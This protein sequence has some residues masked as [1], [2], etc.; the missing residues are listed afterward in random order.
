MTATECQRCKGETP[1][2]LCRECRVELDKALTELPWW[3]D[4]LTEA[5]LGQTRMS[6]NAGRRSAGRRDL[7]GDAELA[8]CIELLPSAG[9]L[10]KA[11]RKREKVA[12]AHALA[13]GG[14]NARASDLLGEIDD[15]LACWCRVLCE[16][17]GLEYQPERSGRALGAN[18]AQWLVRH[19][20]AIAL[21]SD[22]GDIAED[23]L[24]R[25]KRRRG[26]IEQIQA[27][28]NRPWRWWPLGGCPTP[29]R[30]EGPNR[31]GQPHPSAPCGF[32]L[33][34]REDATEIRCRECRT[35][36]RVHRLLWARKREIETEPM[37]SRQLTRYNRELP[38]EY[39]VPPRTL[40][41]W[42][43]TGRLC[44]CGELGGDPLYS[45]VDVRLLALRRPQTAD[46][47]AA[48]HRAQ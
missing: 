37:T 18:H 32:E 34:A 27:V 7:D 19:I 35:V 1:D 33:R 43:A 8:A 39:Q 31:V 30:V 2:F 25:D 21:S 5:A 38:P 11:R 44:A 14:I 15:S 20:H 28:V 23:I 36:H 9:D 42:L 22:A 4:R 47:G 16:D 48:T 29:I 13:T 10:D 45:W 40:R 3:L 24:G 46:T 6:D 41:H 17:R 12:L 26:L